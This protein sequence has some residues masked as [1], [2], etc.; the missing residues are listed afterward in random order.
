[1]LKNGKRYIEQ[2]EHKKLV[3]LC[4]EDNCN[5]LAKNKGGHCDTHKKDIPS[6]EEL[7]NKIVIKNGKKN[8]YDLKESWF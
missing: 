3:A 2:G 7:L 5:N 8:T 4:L 6:K 1:M